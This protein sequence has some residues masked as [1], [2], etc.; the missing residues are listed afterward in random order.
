MQGENRCHICHWV[1]DPASNYDG[2]PEEILFLPEHED[3]HVNGIVNVQ[4]FEL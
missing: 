2:E 4:V 1:I 3:Q